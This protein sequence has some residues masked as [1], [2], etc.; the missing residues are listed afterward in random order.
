MEEKVKCEQC[1]YEIAVTSYRRFI[2]CPCCNNKIPFQGFNYNKIDLT[3]SKHAGAEY[4]SDCPACRGK[5]MMLGSER[6]LWLCADCGYK[7]SDRVMQDEVFW[8]CDECDA[9]LNI[10]AGFTD[11]NNEWMCTDCGHKNSMTEN[12]IF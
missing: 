2:K 3:S 10:Q 1:G 8:F 7:I 4:V 6:K 12:D 5:N 11:K 9:F